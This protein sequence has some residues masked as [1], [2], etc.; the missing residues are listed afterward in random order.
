MT[1]LKHWVTTASTS[2]FDGEPW[3]S[4]TSETVQLP[5]GKTVDGFYRV[6]MRDFVCIYPVTEDGSVLIINQYKHGPQRV[7]LTFPGGHIEADEDPAEAAS[8]E[9]LEETGYQAGTL[10]YLGGY[11]IS[12]NQECGMAHFVR[13]TGCRKVAEPDSGDLEEMEIVALSP[14]EL[15]TKARSGDIVL[16]NQ[17]ALLTF[18]THPELSSDLTD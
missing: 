2:M 14:E 15:W 17:L 11:T 18:A 12:A 10:E 13:A 9:L 6:K 4:V 1:D 16:L 3:V 5:D 7:S 8:R